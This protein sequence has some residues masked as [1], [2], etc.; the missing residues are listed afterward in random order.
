MRQRYKT[1]RSAEQIVS[2]SAHRTQGHVTGSISCA[3][4]SSPQDAL[5]LRVGAHKTDSFAWTCV[6]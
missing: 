2:A 4:S 6:R 5:P 3:A 1:G